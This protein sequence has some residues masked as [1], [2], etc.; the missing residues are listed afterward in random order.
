MDSNITVTLTDKTEKVQ[1]KFGDNECYVTIGWRTKPATF[2]TRHRKYLSFSLSREIIS[3]VGLT[4]NWSGWLCSRRLIKLLCGWQ[5]FILSYFGVLIRPTQHKSFSNMGSLREL[6][7]S[8]SEFQ[9]KDL[10]T[11]YTYSKRQMLGAQYYSSEQG[12]SD[13]K[14]HSVL[15][16]EPGIPCLV[17]AEEFK[18]QPLVY[19]GG[20]SMSGPGS[21]QWAVWRQHQQSCAGERD[22]RRDGERR[23]RGEYCDQEGL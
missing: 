12:C 11:S 6:H 15:L 10:L 16:S 7:I 23:H 20:G 4:K 1:F 22:G 17:T 13:L 14:V 2:Y 9:R 3:F 5:R 8:Y 21:E 19:A 18:T